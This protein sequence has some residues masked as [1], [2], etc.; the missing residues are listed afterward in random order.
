MLTQSVICLPH[1]LSRIIKSILSFSLLSIIK[2][3]NKTDSC[4][5]IQCLIIEK[6]W[7]SYPQD[8][9][10][11]SRAILVTKTLKGVNFQIPLL[12]YIYG[13]CIY[14]YIPSFL[15]S[16]GLVILLILIFH[17]CLSSTL[18]TPLS[19]HSPIL[20]LAHCFTV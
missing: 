6:T 2:S 13:R 12:P 8:M 4:R 16:L 14:I 15:K 9:Q 1:F 20:T 17:N 5:H 18:E 19:P 7:Y 11:I 3:D 10:I